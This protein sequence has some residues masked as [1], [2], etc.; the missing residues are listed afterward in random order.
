M[1]DYSKSPDG[2]RRDLLQKLIDA[3][4]EHEYAAANDHQNK[5]AQRYYKLVLHSAAREAND[6]L[7]AEVEQ[8]FQLHVYQNKICDSATDDEI[9][10]G[11]TVFLE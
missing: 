8:R 1:D 9:I 3:G 11:S 5:F 2:D 10:T 6:E 4:R 7:L